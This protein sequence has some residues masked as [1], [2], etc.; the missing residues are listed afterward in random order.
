MCSDARRFLVAE[1]DR[2]MD[3]LSRILGTVWDSVL[4]STRLQSKF[5]HQWDVAVELPLAARDRHVGGDE[6]EADSD[7]TIS[8]MSFEDDFPSD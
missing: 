6:S 2:A 8:D 5:N 3:R 1:A 7:E 4:K